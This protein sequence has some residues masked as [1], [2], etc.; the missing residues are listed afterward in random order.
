M[1]RVELV[2][3]LRKVDQAASIEAL[4]SLL[5]ISP[6]DGDALEK[7]A[8]VALAAVLCRQPLRAAPKAE[9]EAFA[10]APLDLQLLLAA[11]AH[12]QAAIYLGA[13]NLAAFDNWRVYRTE[14]VAVARYQGL[15]E[16]GGAAGRSI[17]RDKPWCMP[18]AIGFQEAMLAW[19]PGDTRTAVG[20]YSE[21]LAGIHDDERT[22]ESV[23]SIGA[24]ILGML[25]WNP[26]DL[27]LTGLGVMHPTH[28]K[29]FGHLD[30][31]EDVWKLLHDV[32]VEGTI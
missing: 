21:P 8:P 16:W 15:E 29:R 1:D 28:K 24:W 14:Q 12:H 19:S 17:R 4:M 7:W 30:R 6:G 22:S 11:A 26:H 31:V 10:D 32:S 23:P 27:E 13:F 5:T 18:L 2:E 25:A 3:L 20:V 9:H